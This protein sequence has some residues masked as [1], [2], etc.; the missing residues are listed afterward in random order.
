M[1]KTGVYVHIPFCAR[2]CTYCD[3]CTLEVDD[4]VIERYHYALKR[5]IELYRPSGRIDTLYFGGGSP[6]IYP[7]SLLRDLIEKLKESL[8]LDLKEATIES[9]PW[10]LT[11]D[12]LR[13]WQ[14]LGFNRLSIGVQSTDRDIMRVCNRPFPD[15]LVERLTRAV[16]IF[17][18]VNFDFIL[19]LPGENR[20]NVEN[21]LKLIET[22]K[23]EH[24]SYYMFDSDHETGLMTAV[25]NA[26]IE[27]P[28][29][30]LIDELYCTIV[31]SLK[32]LGYERYEISSWSNGRPSLHNLKYWENSDYIGLGLSA[33]GHLGFTRYVNS[34]DFDFY[35]AAANEGKKPLGY[36]RENSMVQEL[37]ETL[38]MGLRLTRGL[39]LSKE[40]YPAELLEVVLDKIASRNYKY[41]EREGSALRLNTR[42]FEMSRSFFEELI[43]IKEEIESAVSS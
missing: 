27:L 41:V 43:D 42:G 28:D 20:I 36:V 19:G 37:F 4:F 18:N 40:V 34:E 25:K 31:E 1:S 24:I 5:E 22:L 11:V 39:D 14:K 38:F 23:P 30:G 33:G 9:N 32:R 13:S 10:E 26:I 12:R 2:K 7:S 6:S 3:F 17:D 29:S 21:S 8:P 35:C 15:D 16:E